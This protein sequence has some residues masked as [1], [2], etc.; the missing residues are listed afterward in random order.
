MIC[1]ILIISLLAQLS[2]FHCGEKV[3]ITAKPNA[4]YRFVEWS[5]GVK[6]AERE[7]E[8][9]SDSTLT[10]RFEIEQATS[11]EQTPPNNEPKP[12]QKI[13]INGHLYILHNGKTYTI[14][15][16]QIP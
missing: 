13:L 3:R 4:G 8:L 2:P 9:Y 12:A 6:E 10:A 7:V 14:Q 5:D 16:S 15:G 1:L 11:I